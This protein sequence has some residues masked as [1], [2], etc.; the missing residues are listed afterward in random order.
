MSMRQ[1]GTGDLPRDKMAKFGW[2]PWRVVTPGPLRSVPR[3]L[4]F[5]VA[6]ISCCPEA[7]SSH[8][9]CRQWNPARL[10]LLQRLAS[11]DFP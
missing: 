1:P 2:N 7:L 11:V 6:Q 9:S 5:E 4:H 3:N 10:L 8:G